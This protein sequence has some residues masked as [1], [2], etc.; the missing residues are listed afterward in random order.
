MTGAEVSNSGTV[1]GLGAEKVS[2]KSTTC[3]F[4]L[5]Y[6]FEL[7]TAV[8]GTNFLIS[9]MYRSVMKSAYH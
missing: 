9:L 4:T 3:F 7:F 2:F 6:K 8:E 5:S 1:A